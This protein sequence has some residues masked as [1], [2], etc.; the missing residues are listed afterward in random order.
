MSEPLVLDACCGSRMFWFDRSD[1]RAIFLDNRREQH[2]L[3]DKS[4][5]GGRRTLI[6]EPDLIGDFT[7]LPFSNGQFAMV[8]FDPPHLVRCGKK[9]WQAKKY[10]KL[11]G[12]WRE[13]LRRGFSECFRVLKPDGALIFKWNEHEVPVSQILAL[14]NER[15]LIGQRCGKTAKTHWIVFMKNSG[16]TEGK[17]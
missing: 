13:M 9:G 2:S 6:I 14:T 10:G 7:R 5:C 3:T 11:E 16:Q 17:G 15:P 1:P 12:D 8:V 4:S